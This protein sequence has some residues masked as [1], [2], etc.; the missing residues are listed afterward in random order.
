MS[1]LLR[2]WAGQ[3]SMRYALLM[4]CPGMLLAALFFWLGSRTLIADMEKVK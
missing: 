4:H 2:P 1:D 3:D